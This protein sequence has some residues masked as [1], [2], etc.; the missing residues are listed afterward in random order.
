MP[1][2]IVTREAGEE[3]TIDAPA[4]ESLMVALR[5]HG[6]G[7]VDEGFGQCGGCCS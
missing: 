4:G 7:V 2:V 3:L 6:N 1:R 5:D